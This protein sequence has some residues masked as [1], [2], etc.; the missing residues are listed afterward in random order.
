M[1]CFRF[2]SHSIIHFSYYPF[3]YGRIF[4]QLYAKAKMSATHQYPKFEIEFGV[5]DRNSKDIGSSQVILQMCILSL[6][7]L[8]KHPPRGWG[9]SNFS[10]REM[11]TLFNS[12]D[13]FCQILIFYFYPLL[14]LIHII[15]HSGP[16]LG[17]IF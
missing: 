12:H 17:H 5:R 13:L 4:L 7:P 2:I 15:G 3:K 14:P 9:F 16:F 1:S 6:T 10:L 8:K 11:R